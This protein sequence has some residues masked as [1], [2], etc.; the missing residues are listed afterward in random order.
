[1][2]DGKYWGYHPWDGKPWNGKR[3]ATIESKTS[4]LEWD[5]SAQTWVA[6]SNNEAQTQ[7][8]PSALDVDSSREHAW[9]AVK[10]DSSNVDIK[11]D[12]LKDDVAVQAPAPI[13][14]SPV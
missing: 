7:A 12:S 11:N 2:T 13:D 8:D 14:V 5:W 3:E 10:K 4:P 6:S 9:S 1:L